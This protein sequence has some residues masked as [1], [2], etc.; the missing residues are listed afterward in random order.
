MK[1]I[2]KVE[3]RS[4]KAVNFITKETEALFEKNYNSDNF[5]EE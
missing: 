2:F 3:R 4:Q 1:R 5:R